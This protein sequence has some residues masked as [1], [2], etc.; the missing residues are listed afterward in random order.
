MI[1]EIGISMLKALNDIKIE[2]QLQNMILMYDYRRGYH[3]KVS[4]NFN[5]CSEIL[6]LQR[7]KL[8]GINND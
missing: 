4:D 6:K 1:D 5:E 3:T 7:D 2:L 8:R